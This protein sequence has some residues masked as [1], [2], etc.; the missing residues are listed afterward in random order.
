MPRQFLRQLSRRAQAI[1]DKWYVRPFAT[2]IFDPRLWSLQRRSVTAGFG[3]GIAIC[4][5]PLPLQV[6]IGLIVAL[7]ARLNVPAV[8]G[9][10]FLVNPFTALPVYLVCYTL[11]TWML[12]LPLYPFAFEPSWAWVQHE[13]L[14]IWRPLLLGCLTLGLV[15][16]FGSW[17]LLDQF[18]LW[19]VRK[20]YR[21]RHQRT[22]R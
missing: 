11:G 16:G 21:E 4:F 3:I 10:T 9:A 13:L 8:V 18:W 7:L 12:G 2:S 15:A 14:L 17:L 6:P 1:R 19:R 20:K 22:Q 5:I